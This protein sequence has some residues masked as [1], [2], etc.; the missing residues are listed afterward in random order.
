[1]HLPEIL[2]S[3]GREGLSRARAE[4]ARLQRKKEVNKSG[5]TDDDKS[6]LVG[7]QDL[8][9]SNQRFT[10]GAVVLGVLAAL[11]A[12]IHS[13]TTSVSEHASEVPSSG[14]PANEAPIH[15]LCSA[16]KTDNL[17]ARIEPG[18]AQFKTRLERNLREMGGFT[19]NSV[20]PEIFWLPFRLVEANAR[21]NPRRNSVQLEEES[22]TREVRVPRQGFLYRAGVV[23]T[24]RGTDNRVVFIASYG[25][26][27]KTLMLPEDFDVNS[28]MDMLAAYHETRHTIQDIARREEL[29]GEALQ[30]YLQ[31]P[32]T[33]S[34][35]EK[36]ADE[37]D[38]FSYELE[39]LNILL[40]DRLRLSQG[41][42]SRDEAIQLLGIHTTREEAILNALLELAPVYYPHGVQ[43]GSFAPAYLSRIQ[44]LYRQVNANENIH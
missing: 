18:F 42:I 10:M 24:E 30:T 39:A 43:G 31:N 26:H 14:G 11:G 13:S 17:I 3:A 12:G 25:S 36:N 6:A 19:A 37:A 33:I 1:M 15:Q 16:E 23:D 40:G 38:A 32:D 35:D 2:T 8:L 7:H 4:I 5:L 20:D 9:R 44:A 29:Q 21:N 34:E 28:A 27:S 41:R 22:R